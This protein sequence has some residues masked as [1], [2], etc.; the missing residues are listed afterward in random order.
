MAHKLKLNHKTLECNRDTKVQSLIDQSENFSD[1]GSNA[2]EYLMQGSLTHERWCGDNLVL[3][4]SMRLL[5]TQSRMKHTLTCLCTTANGLCYHQAENI[6]FYPAKSSSIIRMH[7]HTTSQM[8]E[9]GIWN[10]IFHPLL[11]EDQQN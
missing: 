7:T 6:T 5:L 4:I 3:I 10:T 2:S 8:N 9:T 11:H 1:H